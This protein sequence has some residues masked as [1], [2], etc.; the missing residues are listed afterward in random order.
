LEPL[1]RRRH[2]I[3]E[4]AAQMLATAPGGALRGLAP[5]AIR[6]LSRQAWPGNLSELRRVVELM[7]ETPGTGSLRASDIPASHREAASM[8]TPRAEAERD[9]ILNAVRSAEGNKRRAAELL[10]VSRSTLYNR[11]RALHISA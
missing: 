6:V 4:L 2:E 5:D 9:I 3:P 11:M 8:P 7:A 1:R 10:G